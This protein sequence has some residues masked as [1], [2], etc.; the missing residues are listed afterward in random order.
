MAFSYGI[1]DASQPTGQESLRIAGMISSATIFN[2]GQ[3]ATMVWSIVLWTRVLRC[4]VPFSLFHVLSA[5]QHLLL[6]IECR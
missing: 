5:G 2:S 4:L 1:G 3:P 6:S